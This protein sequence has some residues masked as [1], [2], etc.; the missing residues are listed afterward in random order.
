MRALTLFSGG[1]D[2][3]LII[4]ILVS[5][6]IEVIALHFTTPLSNLDKDKEEILHKKVAELGG[7]LKVIYLGKDFAE[8]LK[9]PRFGYGKNLNPCIDCKILMLKHAKQLMAELGASFVA[10]GEV[11]AQRPK[12]QYKETLR[13][14]EKESGL[15]DLLLRPLSAK[16]LEPTLPEREK[17]INR[18]EL[19]DFNGRSRNQQFKLAE[20]FGIKNFA[21]PAGGCLLTTPSFCGRVEDLL[22]RSQCTPENLELLKTGRHFR[23]SENFKLIVGR[24]EKED[25]EILKLAL[26]E[27]IIFEPLELAGPTALGKGIASA[28]INHLASRIIAKYTAKNNE[29]V[30]VTVRIYPRDEKEIISAFPIEDDKLKQLRV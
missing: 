29:A 23:L 22:K 9:N 7:R 8:I 12:S 21:W 18:D 16:L 15:C 10:T 17:W 6:N 30:E 1:L 11:I 19:F 14:I 2:S 3:S 5:Q 20:H 27:D 24:N 28:D 26:D 13:L 25:N 4:K